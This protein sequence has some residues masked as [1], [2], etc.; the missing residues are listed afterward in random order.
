M[1]IAGQE[2]TADG[3]ILRENEEGENLL[4]KESGTE[5]AD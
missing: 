2:P 3:K 4:Y 5:K 1:E